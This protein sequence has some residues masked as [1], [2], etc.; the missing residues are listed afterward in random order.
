[1]FFMIGT[2]KLAVSKDWTLKE[3]GQL[4][5]LIKCEIDTLDAEVRKM[6]ET[7]LWEAP[8][9]AEAE[10]KSRE[11]QRMKYFA[12]IFPSEFLELNRRKYGDYVS[13]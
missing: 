2:Q 5:A 12:Q 8:Y 4:V 11:L 9:F 6:R 1:M 13:P 3:R 7:I 10:S